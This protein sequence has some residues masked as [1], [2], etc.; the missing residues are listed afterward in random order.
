MVEHEHYKFSRNMLISYKHGK[1]ANDNGQITDGKVVTS[2]V[3]YDVTNDVT[4]PGTLIARD[5]D[6]SGPSTE[7]SKSSSSSSSDSSSSDSGSANSK[8]K[9]VSFKNGL[10]GRF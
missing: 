6:V 7:T 9:I 10:S 4:L 1:R 3:N 2:P 8:K 5:S